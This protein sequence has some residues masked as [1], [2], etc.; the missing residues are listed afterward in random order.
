MANAK[1]KSQTNSS[2]NPDVLRIEEAGESGN[3]YQ[4]V[5][6]EKALK[7]AGFFVGQ[8]VVIC[9]LAGSIIIMPHS[10][11]GVMVAE[12]RSIQ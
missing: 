2:S 12:G 11:S 3:G 10:E 1:Y 7:R 5:I 9:G 8:Q 4:L 6:T